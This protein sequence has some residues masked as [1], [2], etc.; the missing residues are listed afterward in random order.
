MSDKTLQ[1]CVIAVVD[2]ESTGTNVDKDRVITMAAVMVRPG[3]SRLENYW[4][5]DPCVPIPQESTAVHG[6]KDADVKGAPKFR[7][8][9]PEF[10]KFVADAEV[11]VGFNHKAFDLPILAAEFA[12]L[13]PPVQWPPA[14]VL[15]VDAMIIFKQ[16]ERRDLAA[17]VRKFCNHEHAG[18]HNA[19][20]DAQATADVLSGQLAAYQDLAAMTA[21]ELADWAGMAEHVDWAGRLKRRPD[22]VV[23]FNFA[24]VKDVPVTQDRGFAQWMLGGDFPAD[25]KRHVRAILEGRV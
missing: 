3:E 7:D 21:K 16:K 9:G 12:R 1:D 13:S 25:T 8:S 20:A 23:V 14:S 24:K 22:G 15:V 6:I 17:A 11:V 10:C 4:M 5:V 18:A 19:M 2:V